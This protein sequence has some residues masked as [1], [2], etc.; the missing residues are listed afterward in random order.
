VASTTYSLAEAEDCQHLRVV[1]ESYHYELHNAKVKFGLIMA[2]SED[3]HPVKSHGYP[4]LACVKVVPL[5]DRLTKGY[6]AEILVDRHAWNE[7]GT[8]H[9]Q[10]IL[11]HELSHLRL[12]PETDKDSNLPYK[13]D[14][15]GRPKLKLVNGDW[16]AGDGFAEV[17]KRHGKFAVEFTNLAR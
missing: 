17:V 15:L 8:Q 4:A 3:D 10:A 9:K 13:T 7:M 5:K 2:S 16:N 1:L 12:V 14:D 6:D 11:D